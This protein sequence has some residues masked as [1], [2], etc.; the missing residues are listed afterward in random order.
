MS[1]APRGGARRWTVSRAGRSTRSSRVLV[2]IRGSLAIA[3]CVGTLDRSAVED[4]VDRLRVL[5]TQGVRGFVC[6][7]ER[8][9]HIHFQALD[10]LVRLQRALQVTGGRLVL[11]DASPYLR[12]ILDF[13][14]V[15]RQVSVAD[16][17]H[18]A[19]WRLRQ[20][21]DALH[22]QTSVS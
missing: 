17:T 3:Y 19:V 1:A 20:P 13:G 2:S 9:H 5:A 10:P 4:L 22:V 12:Q 11:S 18:E 6:S 8:V 7:L 14:G 15:P 21:E 16:D